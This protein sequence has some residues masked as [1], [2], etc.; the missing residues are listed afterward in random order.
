M[1][2]WPT[3]RSFAVSVRTATYAA[4]DRRPEV[5]G[6]RGAP[7]MD[8]DRAAPKEERP[9]E[10][11]RAQPNPAR[12]ARRGKIGQR[13]PRRRSPRGE[14][15]WRPGAGPDG[16]AGTRA[17]R[18]AC[19]D[20]P[21]RRDRGRPADAGRL[22]R[23]GGGRPGRRGRQDVR[24][25]AARS[26]LPTTPATCSPRTSG[27]S[28]RIDAGHLRSVRVVPS[29]DRQGAPAGLS[30]CDP[31]RGMQTT[32]GASLSDATNLERGE[33]SRPLPAA[34]RPDRLLAVIGGHA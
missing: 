26:R 2:A 27:R 7:D 32:G 24:A 28:H 10:A 18:S 5:V 15:H 19:R 11:P 17:D 29:A 1:R 21:A 31:M 8:G 13:R 33:G 9:G 6:A 4:R 22:E 23:R 12:V 14:Q 34:A 30:A 20:P 25:R 3:G 16:S